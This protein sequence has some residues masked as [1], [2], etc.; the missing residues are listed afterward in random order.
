MLGCVLDVL[1]VCVMDVLGCV[2][3][4]LRYVGV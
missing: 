4:V 3:D 1:G 2:L